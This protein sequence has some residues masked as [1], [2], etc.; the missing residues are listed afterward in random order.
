MEIAARQATFHDKT[1]D[2]LALLTAKLVKASCAASF[3]SLRVAR[4]LQAIVDLNTSA[5]ARIQEDLLQVRRATAR[6][7]RPFSIMETTDNPELNPHLAGEVPFDDLDRAIV[8][9]NSIERNTA[10]QRYIWVQVKWSPTTF[11]SQMVR[12]IFT[13]NFRTNYYFPGG[14]RYKGKAYLPEKIKKFLLNV[15]NYVATKSGGHFDRANVERQLRTLFHSSQVAKEQKKDQERQLALEA[16]G[17]KKRAG[18]KAQLGRQRR[19]SAQPGFHSSAARTAKTS[20]RKA[21]T[22]SRRKA[23]TKIRLP[24][25]ERCFV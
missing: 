12:L 7:D 3:A 2:Q 17:Q 18:R 22:Q 15:T 9:F 8:F 25:T 19:E 16:Q 4:D 23:K 14:L 13:Y 21:K 1:P 5:L 6:L 10:L 24:P 11:T 20:R